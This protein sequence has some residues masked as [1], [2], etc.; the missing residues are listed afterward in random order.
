MNFINAFRNLVLKFKIQ[1]WNLMKL[2][3]KCQIWLKPSMKPS[4]V[5]R[6]EWTLRLYTYS[7]NKNSFLMFP[8]LQKYI[9]FASY[10]VLQC[11]RL[12]AKFPA[13][14]PNFQCMCVIAYA[15]AIHLPHMWYCSVG[16]YYPNFQHMCKISNIRAPVH[17]CTG[18]RM[19]EILHIC[20]KF[21]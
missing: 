4:L 3:L 10:V 21:G 20:W 9:L 6:L 17:M 12:L 13:Y 1:L 16:D 15:I 7:F 5:S 2:T 14:V 19:L 18:A 8:T 11:R